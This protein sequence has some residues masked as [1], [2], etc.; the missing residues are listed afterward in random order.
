MNFSSYLPIIKSIIQEYGRPVTVY[1]DIFVNEL[2][3]QVLKQKG[4]IVSNINIVI[5]NSS[6]SNNE[7]DTN[8]QSLNKPYTSATGYYAYDGKVELRHGDYFIIDGI[9]YVMH[10]P[11]DLVHTHL[12]Y[13]VSLEGV[14]YDGR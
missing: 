9:K 5:D 1:R 2:G 4:F 8:S 11:Q 3:T 12:V 13:Q 6:S 14:P 7:D 10:I